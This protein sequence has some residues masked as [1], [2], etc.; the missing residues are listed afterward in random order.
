[1]PFYRLLLSVSLQREPDRPDTVWRLTPRAV[2]QICGQRLQS[3]TRESAEGNE[4]LIQ[5]RASL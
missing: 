3:R 1:M 2:C 4:D 5:Y